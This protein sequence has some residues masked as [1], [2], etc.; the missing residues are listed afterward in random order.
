LGRTNES[1]D[2]Y[3]YDQSLP[4]DSEQR[5][6]GNTCI[7]ICMY[8]GTNLT[9]ASLCCVLCS[10]KVLLGN[11][12]LLAGLGARV[13]PNKGAH[14]SGGGEQFDAPNMLL[15][16][17]AWSPL[18]RTGAGCRRAVRFLLLPIHARK[19]KKK[20]EHVKTIS[21][22][23]ISCWRVATRSGSTRQ[24]GLLLCLCSGQTVSS[25]EHFDFS[26]HQF[27]PFLDARI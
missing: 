6:R 16:S 23:S 7:C 11:G 20:R 19:R 13:A 2:Y 1:Q 21:Q 24:L 18:A 22:S 8:V 10:C 12:K 27:Q 17:A 5:R 25:A 9:L 3:Y 26:V 4:L 14:Q 15:P